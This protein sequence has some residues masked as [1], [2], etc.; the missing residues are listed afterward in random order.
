MT[1]SEKETLIAEIEKYSTAIDFSSENIG[2]AIMFNYCIDTAEA[3]P[4][5]SRP[6]LV[7]L[8]DR[9]IIQNYVA[10]LLEKSISQ[11][12]ASS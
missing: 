11:P 2:K 10:I 5:H 1:G 3:S 6:Y 8:P 4:L 9:G 7:S 12:S